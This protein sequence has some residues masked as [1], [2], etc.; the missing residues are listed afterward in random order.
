MKRVFAII[1]VVLLALGM[2][3]L[4]FASFLQG[5]VSTTPTATY[6]T[7]PTPVSATTVQ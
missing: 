3:G 7:T 5:G 1:I 6:T 4:F 2:V